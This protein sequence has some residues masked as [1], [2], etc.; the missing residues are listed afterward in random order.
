MLANGKRRM[1]FSCRLLS[2]C[3]LA[4][5]TPKFQ[6]YPLSLADESVR[7][8]TASRG[9]KTDMSLVI[10]S[11][12]GNKFQMPNIGGDWYVFSSRHDRSPRPPS[13]REASMLCFT[14]QGPLLPWAIFHTTSRPICGASGRTPDWTSRFVLRGR[15][16]VNE[17]IVTMKP[18]AATR[19]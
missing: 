8:H 9:Y 17:L 16:G 4:L 3:K 12:S 11:N 13:M 19:G 14:A 10:F 6:R 18:E 2:L 5:R 7:R 1:F 15:L